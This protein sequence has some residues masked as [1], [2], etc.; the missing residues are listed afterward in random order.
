MN[1][2]DA[3][4]ET[5]PLASIHQTQGGSKSTCG[6]EWFMQRL[7]IIMGLIGGTLVAQ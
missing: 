3:T 5:C 4:R 2:W 1:Q 6:F 7:V